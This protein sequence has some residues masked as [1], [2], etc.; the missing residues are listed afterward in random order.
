MS[1]SYNKLAFNGIQIILFDRNLGYHYSTCRF[2]SLEDFHLPHE[3]SQWEDDYFPSTMEMINDI[4]P[5]RWLIPLRALDRHN[6]IIWEAL[7]AQRY[8]GSH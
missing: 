5:E 2:D 1:A 6:N 7:G 8:F 3:F 4:V